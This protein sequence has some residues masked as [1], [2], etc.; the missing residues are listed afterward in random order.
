DPLRSDIARE[1]ALRG[2]TVHEHVGGASFR[3]DLG[4]VSEDGSDFALGILIDGGT[5]DSA[6]KV[7]ERFVFKPSILRAF[8]WRV[9]DIPSHSW[10]QDNGHVIALI[11]AELDR[12]AQPYGDDDPFTDIPLPASVSVPVTAPKGPAAQE[13]APPSEGDWQTFRF[14][15]GTSDK[16]WRVALRGTD[17][18]VNYGRSGTKGQS[19]TKSFDDEGRAKR[20][21]NKLILE[22]TRKGYAEE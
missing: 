11:E 2:H 9:I 13:V 17:L 19:V 16:F 15:K 8:G 5:Y 18:V 20:E 12:G 14:R 21:M 1:L 4:L 6:R 10:R 22:K 3:C 7:Y